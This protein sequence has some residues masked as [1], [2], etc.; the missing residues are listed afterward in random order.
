MKRRREVHVG[1]EP[2]VST[3]GSISLGFVS[4]QEEKRRKLAV[5]NKI[6]LECL[7]IVPYL[8]HSES[9]DNRGIR[10]NHMSDGQSFC[11]PPTNPQV[12]PKL[13]DSTP[14]PENTQLVVWRGTPE[15]V[16]K[17]CFPQQH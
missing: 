9:L 3:K 16:V 15:D 7:S 4:Q 11:I 12:F 2:E 8:H 13:G 10:F 17:Q 6:N 14:A 5:E 1:V